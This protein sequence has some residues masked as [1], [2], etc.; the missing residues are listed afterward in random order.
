MI[1]SMAKKIFAIGAG[2]T[3]AHTVLPLLAKENTITTAGR[4]GCDV[5]CDVTEKVIIPENVDTVINFAASLASS[6]DEE[7]DSVVNTNVGGILQICKAARKAGVAHVINISSIFALLDNDD[8][9]L[10]IYALTKRHADELASFYCQRSALPL[11]IVRPSRIYGDSHDFAKGQPFFYKLIDTAGRGDD[12]VL[13]ASGCAKR[14]Y[15]HANDIAEILTRVISSRT[16]GTYTCAHP[17][18]TTYS[19]IAEAAQKTFG[20]GGQII[21]LKDKPEPASDTT[22]HTMPLY[23]VIDFRPA[24]TM[25][26]GIERIKQHRKKG[27]S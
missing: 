18:D 2:S 3:L 10:S 22:S 23:D 1:Q 13:Y 6:S 12:I 16:T 24:I 5:Y 19:Q 17:S 7:L 21:R 11:T 8:P 27:V 14:N 20:K 26:A 25:E 9:H 4:N 15:I